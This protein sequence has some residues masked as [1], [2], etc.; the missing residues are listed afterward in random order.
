MK[1]YFVDWA[2]QEINEATDGDFIRADDPELI[3]A[4]QDARR[5]K[6]LKQMKMEDDQEDTDIDAM[7]DR[8]IDVVA[9]AAGEQEP[10]AWEYFLNGVGESFIPFGAGP[11]SGGDL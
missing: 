8:L 10:V 4:L 6:M 9:L 5:Y 1:R 3:Q 11:G 7:L 2:W